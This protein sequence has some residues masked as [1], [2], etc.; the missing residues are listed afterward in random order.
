MTKY[1]ISL[2]LI[3]LVIPCY[4]DRDKLYVVSTTGMIADAL[5]NV[6][7]DLITVDSLMG[8]GVDP[9][10]Y[11]ATAND[12][13]KLA[14]ADII[15]YNGLHLEGKMQKILMTMS[16]RKIV[17]AITNGIPE[18]KLIKPEGFD[19]LHDP[20]IWFNVS[21]WQEAVKKITGVLC[22]VDQKN[23]QA[24]QKNS[25]AYIK[26]LQTLHSWAQQQ[27]NLI[28]QKSR[29][30]ITAHDA[31][32]YMGKAYG[33]EVMGLQGVSTVTESGIKDI[34]R[35]VQVIVSRNIK[36]IFE[37]TSVMNKGVEAVIE[38][39]KELGHEVKMGG[40]LFSDAM[41]EPGTI[42][43]TYVGMVEHNVK[44]IVRALSSTDKE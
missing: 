22:G 14:R 37:E 33:F 38:H 25:E 9:H 40:S 2:L 26:K 41:G 13:K 23:A 11:K 21:L 5:E 3:L 42:E 34:E 19:G 7:G 16:R 18:S 32:G 27:I 30:L 6:G 10:L 28:P 44:T 17:C 24:Y 1:M 35:I 4:A 36:A 31:F 39:C 20:H 43:G 12:T 29:V 8:P 15:F